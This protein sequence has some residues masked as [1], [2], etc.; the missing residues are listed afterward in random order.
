MGLAGEKKCDEDELCA[1]YMKQLLQ[2]QSP[3]FEII[4]NHLKT[5]ETARK[6]FDASK[7]HFPV[8]DFHYAMD[9]D[10]FSFVVKAIRSKHRTVLKK[11]DT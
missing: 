4:K 8:K 9:L 10:R 6:F 11:E 7:P 1:V 3:D 5:Y 2:N